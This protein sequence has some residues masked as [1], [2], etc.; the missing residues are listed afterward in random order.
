MVMV[1]WFFMVSIAKEEKE[2][3][4]DYLPP[5]RVPHTPL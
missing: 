3:Y 1:D 2:K 4:E 5:G